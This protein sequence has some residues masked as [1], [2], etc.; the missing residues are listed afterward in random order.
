LRRTVQRRIE[1]ALAKRML[2]GEFGEGDV[3]R[4][5]FNGE[6]FTFEKAGRR[7]REPEREAVAAAR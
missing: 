5:D 3:V 7:E 6:D 2:A 4:V 1:N